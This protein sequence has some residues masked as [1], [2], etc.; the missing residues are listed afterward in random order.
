[1]QTYEAWYTAGEPWA[2]SA[3]LPAE[4]RRTLLRALAE[5]GLAGPDAAKRL[6][7]CVAAFLFTAEDCSRV[8]QAICARRGPGEPPPAA[9]ALAV[10][11]GRIVARALPSLTVA[12]LLGVLAA[13]PSSDG[14]YL[15][16]VHLLQFLLGPLAAGLDLERRRQAA[17]PTGVALQPADVEAIVRAVHPRV[18][19]ATCRMLLATLPVAPLDVGTV[20]R[21]L[22]AIPIDVVTTAQQPPGSGTASLASA[23]RAATVT[24]RL[25][26]LQLVY[27]GGGRGS[28]EGRGAAGAAIPFDA[29]P[30]LLRRL[31]A[32]EVPEGVAAVLAVLRPAGTLSGLDA[33]LRLAAQVSEPLPAA[34]VDGPGSAALLVFRMLYKA[35]LAPPLSDLAT[36]ATLLARF[37]NGTERLQVLHALL[38]LTAPPSVDDTV[39]VLER[40]PQASEQRAV[41]FHLAVVTWA[42]PYDAR[43]LQTA[44]QLVAPKYRAE[45]LEGAARQLPPLTGAALAAVLELVPTAF[46]HRL[47]ALEALR[48]TV[49]ALSCD[50]LAAIVR[51]FD[52]G[53]S[54]LEALAV[55]AQLL[56]DADTEAARAALLAL[57]PS[58]ADKRAAMQ[59]LQRAGVV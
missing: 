29:L 56:T 46:R 20:E 3:W 33:V 10:E 9:V 39:A 25:S 59:A 12:Q 27:G 50:E 36:L 4:H 7:E 8:I 31:P 57:F 23:H 35:H 47:T 21:L 15:A 6:Y 49:P 37:A 19:A 30:A 53:R 40:F 58:T 44:L 28:R 2:R 34:G 24:L 55:A 52:T 42:Q 45:A 5:Q 51:G 54:R 41:A 32:A 1:M 18:A 14:E 17:P 43:D 48:H 13:M 38:R 16:R 22:D 11:A 26:L